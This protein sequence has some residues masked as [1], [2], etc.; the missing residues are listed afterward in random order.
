M[1][2]CGMT[3]SVCAEAGIGGNGLVLYVRL[4]AGKLVVQGLVS[5]RSVPHQRDELRPGGGKCFK[6]L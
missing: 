3:S 5:F 2:Y 1:K 4:R 6:C